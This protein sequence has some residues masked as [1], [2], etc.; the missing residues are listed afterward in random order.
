M[1]RSGGGF[2]AYWMAEVPFATTPAS[3]LLKQPLPVS[4]PNFNTFPTHL[5]SSTA[6]FQ[7]KK[8]TDR[9]NKLFKQEDINTDMTVLIEMAYKYR[10]EYIDGE[11]DINS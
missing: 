11:Q 2:S 9:T 6:N 1:I 7:H 10:R 4:N 3:N 8:H 5:P